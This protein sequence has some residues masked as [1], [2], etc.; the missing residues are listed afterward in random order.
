MLRV[1]QNKDLKVAANASGRTYFA[2]SGAESGE[3]WLL[4]KIS[5]I[6][7]ATS[8]AHG[9]NYASIG[10]YKGSSTSLATARTT[11]STDLTQGTA[12]DLSITATGANLEITQASPLSVRVAQAASGV[13]VDC[14]I[15]AEFE[16]IRS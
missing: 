12:E 3:T 6:P 11:A 15:Q 14:S 8:T 13:A 5:L 16:V 4:K 10:A 2:P 1:K 7:N 9:T